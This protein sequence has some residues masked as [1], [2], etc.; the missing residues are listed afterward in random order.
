MEMNRKFV[1]SASALVQN[2]GEEC[3]ILDLSTGT[4]F[5]LDPVGARAWSLLTEGRSVPAIIETLLG[6]YE[7]Q[8]QDLEKDIDSLLRDLRASGLIHDG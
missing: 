2:V 5:G 7:V 4:Y 1:V 6:E 8:R 3:V